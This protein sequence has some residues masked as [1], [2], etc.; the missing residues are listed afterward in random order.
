MD[1]RLASVFLDAFVT[2]SHRGGNVV[3]LIE[4]NKFR[5]HYFRFLFIERYEKD[6]SLIE[7]RR[8][9]GD[10][11]SGHNTSLFIKIKSRYWLS[12]ATLRLFKISGILLFTRRVSELRSALIKRRH[13]FSFGEINRF[14]STHG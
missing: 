9:L 6:Q 13:V 11:Q 4:T 1:T 3:S 7:N 12:P 10:S 8:P 2:A 14:R 5:F